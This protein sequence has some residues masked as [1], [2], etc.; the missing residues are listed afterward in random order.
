MFF[1]LED[2]I[3]FES[4]VEYRAVNS[5][6]FQEKKKKTEAIGDPATLLVSDTWMRD[7]RS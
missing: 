7:F 5:I 4:S 6:S 3:R 2:K 1:R